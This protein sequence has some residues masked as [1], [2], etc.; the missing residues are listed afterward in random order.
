MLEQSQAGLTVC[1]S[2]SAGARRYHDAMAALRPFL[3]S[4]AA[5]A[6]AVIVGA[7]LMRAVVPAGFMPMATAHGIELVL[8]S[9]MAKPSDT[10]IAPAA[11]MMPGIQHHAMPDHAMPAGAD[12]EHQIPAKPEAPCAFAGLT[13]PSIGGAD[14]VLLAIAFASVVAA[15]LFQRPDAPIRPRPFLRPPLR[16]PPAHA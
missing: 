9:G 6:W 4:N 15:A 10:T 12:G 5:L 7:L 3:H 13:A 16:G 11:G 1:T 14:I 2:D 8:C